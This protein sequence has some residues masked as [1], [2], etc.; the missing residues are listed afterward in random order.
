MKALLSIILAAV[1]GAILAGTVPL[2]WDVSPSSS[3]GNYRLLLSTNAGGSS[4]T[5]FIISG[6]Q[7][8]NYDLS[9]PAGI[10][11]A[12][13]VAITT[14]GITSD[15]SNEVSFEVPAGV[16]LRIRIQSAANVDGPWLDRTNVIAIELAKDSA[17]FYRTRV[18]RL[19]FVSPLTPH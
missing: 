7:S 15:P 4:V 2:A 19:P 14:N 5:N 17:R 9:V 3:V 1:A 11:F 12:R 18:D 8:T 10:W 6:R 16:Q 13:M